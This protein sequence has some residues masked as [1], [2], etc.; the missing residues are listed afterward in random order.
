MM[1]SVFFI[2]FICAASGILCTCVPEEEPP[3]PYV[4]VDFS[5]PLANYP[6]LLG[7]VPIKYGKGSYGY[8]KNGI[9]I[10]PQGYGESA[11][12]TAYDA[13]CTH[14]IAQETASI[15]ID[16]D[17]NTATCPRCHTVYN[18]YNGYAKEAT[19]HLQQYA[20]RRSGDRL[21]ITT[22]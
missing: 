13:T 11:V 22:Y 7:G 14:N 5:L 18:L 10:F 4:M 15:E 16:K 6:N 21:F 19:F 2:A 1:R 12:F 3:L 8:N 17:G 9:I 20:S